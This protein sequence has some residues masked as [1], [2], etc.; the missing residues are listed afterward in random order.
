MALTDTK[1]RSAKPQEKEYTLVD[2]DGMFLL[3]HPN[4]SKYWRFRFRFGGKQHLMAFGVY[5][6]TSLAGARQKRE[7]ARKLVA[8]GIDPREHKRAVKEE[9][10]ITFESVARDWHASN[11][12][13]SES[14][15]GRV[16]KSLEDNLFDTIG[17]RNIAELKT[18]DL[19]IPIKAVEMS[20]RL[21]VAARLQQRTTAIMRFAV[22][23]GLIDYNPAQ[24]I[25]G[26]VATAKRQHRAALELN[27]I[28]ELL[29]RIDTYTGRPL[30]RLAVELTLLVFIRSSELRFARWS[31]V[32]FESAMWTIPGEREHL[33]GV[34]HSHRGSK[35][36]TPHLVP[37]SRQALAILEKIKCMNGNRE[38]IFVGDHDPR[39]PMSENTVNKA[40]RVMGYDTKVEVCGHGFRTMAC[41]S[42]IESG[43]WS[44]D[45]VERQMSHQERNSVRAAYIHKAE[46][47]GERRLM[48]QWWA[49]YL[50]VNREKV[51]SPFEFGRIRLNN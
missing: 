12:K 51:V 49:D 34:K 46:H 43:L 30:T 17:K 10:A 28:P 14:H 16:L 20:G 40:L 8:A 3:I 15:S 11:Q 44:K 22:Q 9:Q 26:A 7:E 36:R 5:P 41:S 25:A 42:L 4:G 29:H 24:E 50:D 1:V 45:A 33:E 18:R 31:E 38:L 2:G 47:L 35:M 48:L 23:S 27:R 37:L 32:D 19:L 13:W 39:K 21:E 6:E